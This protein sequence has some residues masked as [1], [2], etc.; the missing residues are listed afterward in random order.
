MVRD[1]AKRPPPQKKRRRMPIV[2][3]ISVIAIALVIPTVMYYVR[4]QKIIHKKKLLL[5]TQSSK[6]AKPKV[7]TPPAD[8]KQTKQSEFDFYTIL[9]KMQVQVR[10]TTST[11]IQISP[12][13]AKGHYML[14]VASLQSLKQAKQFKDKLFSL[15]YL[16]RIT[17]FQSKNGEVWNRVIT[18][19]YNSLREAEKAQTTLQQHHIDSILLQKS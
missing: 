6:S 7:L 8:T 16:A 17:T 18:G 15:G 3:A 12:Q 1:Y 2:I 14:Q 19:P 11:P 5:P 4:Y 13:E 9:P 10:S